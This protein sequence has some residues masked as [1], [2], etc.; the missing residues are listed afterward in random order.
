MSSLKKILSKIKKIKEKTEN[1][2]ESNT[3]L[4]E[5][6]L[7][8]MESFLQ[9]PIQKGKKLDWTKSHELGNNVLG[10]RVPTN[11]IVK[12]V[13]RSAGKGS[14]AKHHHDADEYVEVKEGKLIFTIDGETITVSQ[15]ES[16]TIPKKVLHSAVVDD[17]S[18]FEVT[19]K[20]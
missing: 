1:I 4:S 7:L 9:F 8:K 15:N 18:K 6:G 2:L 13:F 19:F 17:Y 3:V 5:G 11:H 20:K 10:I 16:I 14:Y 12:F